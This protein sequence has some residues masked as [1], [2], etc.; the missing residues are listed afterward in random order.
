MASQVNKDFRHHPGF[1]MFPDRF[2]RIEDEF[3]F[4]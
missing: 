4:D 3:E 2:Y 1:G